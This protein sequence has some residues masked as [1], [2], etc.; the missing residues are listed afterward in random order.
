MVDDPLAVP[1]SE[2][3]TAQVTVAGVTEV[4]AVKVSEVVPAEFTTS[5]VASLVV[6]AVTEGP[7]ALPGLLISACSCALPWTLPSV[8]VTSKVMRR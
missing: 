2:P 5:F 6:R 8:Q 7:T 3:S 4:V 1:C